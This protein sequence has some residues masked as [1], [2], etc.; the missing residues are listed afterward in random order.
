MASG[1]TR[2]S[3]RT[4]GA[5]GQALFGSSPEVVPLTP[6]AICDDGRGRL[7]VTD[8]NAG[9]V[10]A[11]DVDRGSSRRWRPEG[12][13]SQPVGIAADDEG[14][15]YVSDSAAGTIVVLD[16]NGN[17]VG[18]LGEGHLIRPCGLAF[19]ATTRELYVADAGWHKLIVLDLAGQVLR[20][21]GGRGTEPGQFNYPTNV[22]IDSTGRVYVSDTLNFR[23][24]VLSPE[25]APV[26]VIGSKG[27]LPGYFSQPKGI[28]LDSE[29]HLYVVDSHFES[30]QIF[31]ADGRLL[32]T[33][34]RE[35]REPGEFWLPSGIYIDDD[36][37]IY[38]ADTYNQRVQ[39]FEYRPEVSP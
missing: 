36:D 30:V 7:L 10:H 12:G 6:Y 18:R 27:D 33:F 1:D 4:G 23:V 25:L 35:G 15:V 11:M 2:S 20:S 21:V 34:G 19:D 29:D 28:A 14:R 38:I 32:L 26:G 24:Q 37:R 3:E 39:V 8:T 13:L 5:I 31:G 16:A 9:V 17:E 22:A